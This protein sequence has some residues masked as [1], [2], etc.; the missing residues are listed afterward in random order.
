MTCASPCRLPQAAETDRGEKPK[1]G[2]DPSSEKRLDDEAETLRDLPSRS[3]EPAYQ[4][5]EDEQEYRGLA[6]LDE[7]RGSLRGTGRGQFRRPG[8]RGAAPENAAGASRGAR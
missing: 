1:A 8:S 4:P 2:E 7:T 6:D 5:Y 3:T